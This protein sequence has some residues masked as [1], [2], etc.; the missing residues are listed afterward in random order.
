MEPVKVVKGIAVPLRRPDVDTD[1]IIPKQ[2]LKSIHRTGFGKHLFNDWRYIEG[3]SSRPNPEFVLNL[4]RYRDA[5]ILVATGTFGIGSSREH[6]PWALLDYG[7]RCVI[8]PGFGDI[9]YNNSQKNGLLLAMVAPAEADR[10]IA[11]IEAHAGCALEVDLEARTIA[12]LGASALRMPFQIDAE[13]RTRLLEG[14]DDI[15]IT[16]KHE[17]EIAR[18]EQARRQSRPWL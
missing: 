12:S 4:P 8:A 3:D 7:F 18:F 14:L 16:L 9:F 1:A 5:R 17:P 13:A 10:L 2:F 15:G 6:A 11:E